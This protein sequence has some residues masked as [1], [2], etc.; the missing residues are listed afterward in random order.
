M[1]T[2]K[3][4]PRSVD[5]YARH[6]RLYLKPAL[7]HI[8]LAKLAPQDVDR[9]MRGLKERKL[10]PSTVRHARSVLRSAL[11]HAMRQDLIGR[12]VAALAEPPRMPQTERPHLSVEQAD[13]LL[14]AAKGERLEALWILLLALGLRRAE[15]FGLRW[16]DVD[17]ATGEI[18]IRKALHRA[19]GMLI[20]GEPKTSKGRR[21]LPMPSVVASALRAHKVRQLEL[22]R[23]WGTATSRRPWTS[24][25]TSCRP[26][27]AKPRTRWTGRERA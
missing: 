18:K 14:D 8:R 21:T 11:N 6:V 2:P 9:M 7:G 13:A 3:A 22:W 1:I 15:A 26:A 27:S 4:T 10:S 24:T 12:N 17:F 20:L 23:S 16:K 5:T 19:N 25:R